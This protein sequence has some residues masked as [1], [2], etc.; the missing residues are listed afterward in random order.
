MQNNVTDTAQSVPSHACSLLLNHIQSRRTLHQLHVLDLG[1]SAVFA[2][3]LKSD[4]EQ[5]LF[6][7]PLAF[8]LSML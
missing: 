8:I 6:L 2:L 7:S 5:F 3:V 1:F 4:V